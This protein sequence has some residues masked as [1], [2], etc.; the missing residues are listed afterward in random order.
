MPE[1]AIKNWRN[2][3][4][5]GGWGVTYTLSGQSFSFTGAPA[6]IVE[7]IRKVQVSNGV[8]ESDDAIWDYV[9][10]VW[11]SRD[12]TRCIRSMAFPTESMKVTRTAR[13]RSG[14]CGSCGGGR[15]R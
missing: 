13:R 2:F 5:S 8:Y 14:G 15:V 1:P 6:K 7:Q 11:C 4:P 9:N 12:T 3:P 10:A